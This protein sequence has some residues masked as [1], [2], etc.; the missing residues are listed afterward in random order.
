MFRIPRDILI[1]FLLV[2]AAG[3][4]LMGT[5]A[6]RFADQGF[7]DAQIGWLRSH[8]PTPLAQDVVVI[9]IDEAAFVAIPEP[10]ALWH[11]HL[12]T[13]FGGLSAAEP[14]VVGL[15]LPL[16]TGVRTAPTMTA[17]RSEYPGMRGPPE[18]RR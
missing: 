11:T 13:L 15:A 9:G 14:A 5:R 6:L 16:P 1:G 8:S 3:W 12:G 17:S 2:C 4:F 18:T 7:Y 10:T